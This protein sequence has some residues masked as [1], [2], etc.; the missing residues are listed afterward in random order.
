MRDGD[1]DLVALAVAARGEIES[2]RVAPE[3]RVDE[4]IGVGG[5]LASDPVDPDACARP[6][7]A[8]AKR[9]DIGQ[10]IEARDVRAVASEPPSRK[11]LPP[12]LRS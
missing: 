11:M 10:V 5:G 3:D 6:F 4:G 7:A 12:Q 1:P 2:R 9:A 8:D